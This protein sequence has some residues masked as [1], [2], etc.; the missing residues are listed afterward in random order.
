MKLKRST[1]IPLILLVYLGVMAYI[2]YPG[3]ASGATSALHYFGVIV[4]TLGIIVLLH[5]SI[6]RR[7]RLRN[8][9]MAEMERSESEQENKTTL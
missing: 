6:K 2:G 3:Y 9:R 4:A 8:E 7:E 1:F 5:F